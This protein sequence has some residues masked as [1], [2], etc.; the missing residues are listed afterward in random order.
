M[1]M[2]IN[3]TS[4]LEEMVR[5][6]VVS[7]LYTSASEVVQ[8]ALRLMDEK[9]QLEIAK[10]NQLRADV[11]EGLSS[12]PA[13]EWNPADLKAAGREARRIKAGGAA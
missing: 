6:K 7:G 4:H 3:L 11:Q 9:D 10:V 5:Q 13:T 1:S 2:K 12:G 8:E